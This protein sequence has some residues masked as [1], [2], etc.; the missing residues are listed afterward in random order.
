[1]VGLGPVDCAT[2]RTVGASLTGAREAAATARAHVQAGRDPI[3]ERDRERAERR[4]EAANTATFRECARQYIRIH[5]PGW[6]NAKHAAQWA[7]TLETYAYPAIGDLPARDVATAHVLRILEPIWA[8]KTETATRV[9]QRVE[10][11]LD[12]AKVQGYRDGENPA[13]WR[14]HLDKS[15]PKPGKVK[16]VRHHPA[17]PYSEIGAFMRELAAEQGTAARCLEFTIYTAARTSEARAARWSEIDLD[18][19]I[20]TVPADRIKSRREHRV[21]LPPAA[22]AILK[23]QEGHD[24]VFVFPGIR[25]GRPLSDMAMLELL[26]GRMQKPFTVHG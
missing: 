4:A 18:A 21:P 23:R 5:A 7:A 24:P 1:D 20:W 15:L 26:Q 22:V 13:R 2:L 9:R 17:M 12:W 25:E 11:V 16:R 8:T 3:A 6:K 14:G 19:A 10:A